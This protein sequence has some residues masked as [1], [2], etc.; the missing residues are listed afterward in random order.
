MSL[1]EVED[2]EVYY[3]TDE[4]PAQAVDGVSFSLEAGENLGIVGE[5]GCGKTTLAKAL[6]GILPNE[7]Y[8]NAGRIEFKGDDLTE[9][10]DS[11][12]RRLKWE[13]ISMIAQSAM[14]SLD[15]VYTIR[16]QIVEAIETHRPG[17]G[18]VESTEIVTEMFELVGLDP[19][20]A[21]DYPH[22]FSGGMRQRAMIAMALALEPSLILA[23]EPTT[24]LDVIMQDQILKRISQI[25]DEIQSSML[26]ITH[27]VSVVAETCDR[28]LVMYAGK[29]AEEGPVE[30]IFNQPYHPYTIGLKR[31]FPN[32]RQPEQDLLSIKG[33]PPELVDPPTGCRFAARCPMATDRCR[34]EEPKAHRINGL[35][36]YCHYAEDIDTELRPHADRSET[37][38]QTEAAQQAGGD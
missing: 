14:N 16:E 1:L 11:E 37:W 4:G 6:I 31:A 34:E 28:V 29:V 12:R 33:Y 38:N 10:S 15:P 32:I 26:V 13:E 3:E 30:E 19:D 20:R 9:M 24:A 35:R 5:S 22:Q 25:Q 21:D 18:R 36:S 2:L 8:V 17:T 7:G 23:D 27:D